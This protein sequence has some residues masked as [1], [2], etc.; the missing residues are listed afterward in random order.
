[1]NVKNFVL[2]LLAIVVTLTLS[3]SCGQD[4][5][6]M[7]P[8]EVRLD[9][10]DYYNDDR[11]RDVTI[12]PATANGTEAV[13]IQM[14][15]LE[16][17]TLWHSVIIN[18]EKQLEYTGTEKR[19][20]TNPEEVKNAFCSQMA[21]SMTLLKTSYP[22]QYQAIVEEFIR[23]D[24]HACAHYIWCAQADEYIS[25]EFRATPSIELATPP[26]DDDTTSYDT[27]GDTTD[28]GTT[29]TE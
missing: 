4:Y 7:I 13:P 27:T 24:V 14:S 11:L 1:M 17:R 22:Q 25:I 29:P 19:L 6:D 18:A 10:N 20:Y 16:L 21:Q 2:L 15:T 23:A 9:V 26:T 12:T 5:T 28:S 8:G 3:T